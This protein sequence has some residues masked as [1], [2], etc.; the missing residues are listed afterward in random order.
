MNT[1]EIGR[2]I[3][4]FVI[5]LAVAAVP[6]YLLLRQP[7]PRRPDPIVVPTYPV[8]PDIANEMRSALNDAVGSTTGG[9]VALASDGVL[10]VS[11]RESVQ[12][13]VE[14]LIKEVAA[15][16]PEATPSI[17]FEVWVISG[18]PVTGPPAP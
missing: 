7:P 14:A 5:G 6:A 3:V 4:W 17:H 13:G 18:A 15:K 1:R 11:A 12:S 9:R 16:K 8:R 10:V 2:G